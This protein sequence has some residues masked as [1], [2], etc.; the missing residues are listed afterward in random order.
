MVRDQ[1]SL[2][3]QDA[4]S[5]VRDLNTTPIMNGNLIRGVVLGTGVV[6]VPHG[7]GRP[8]LGWWVVDQNAPGSVHRDPRDVA[9]LQDAL[10]LMADRSMTVTLWV[11]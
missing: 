8:F 4:R 7:L 10:P 2:F 11:F 3:E 5:V 6:R 1:D 9:R